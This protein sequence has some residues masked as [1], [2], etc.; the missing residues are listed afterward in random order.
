M[1]RPKSGRGGAP[2]TPRTRAAR[3]TTWRTSPQDLA[4]RDKSDSSR[5]V[6]PLTKAADA[7]YIDTTGLPI[8]DVVARV[9]A[10]V[11]EKSR[12]SMSAGSSASA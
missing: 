4:I 12:R 2:P 6:S 7:V 10:L 1:P 5:S 9:V 3:P 11:R 8:D